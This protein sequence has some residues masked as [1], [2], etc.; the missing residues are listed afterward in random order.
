M[1]RSTSSAVVW[2]P[3]L[4]LFTMAVKGR[5]QAASISCFTSSVSAAFLVR[6]LAALMT[7][8]IS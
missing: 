6:G 7:K 8:S 3:R 5:W 4:V 1:L 2:V